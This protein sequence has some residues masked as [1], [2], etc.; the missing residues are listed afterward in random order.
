MSH[1]AE[2][3]K[4]DLLNKLNEQGAP[5]GGH[6]RGIGIHI[7]WQDGELGRGADRKPQNGAYLEDVLEACLAR[8]RFFQSSKLNCPESVVTLNG[9]EDALKWLRRRTESREK[10]KVE[11]T[12]LP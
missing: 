4:L 7:L 12:H 5:T 2:L 10:R 1:M 8:L 6:V 3:Q 9:L 11:G